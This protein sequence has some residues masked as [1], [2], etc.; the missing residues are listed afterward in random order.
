MS[1]GGILF[2]IRCSLGLTRPHSVSPLLPPWRSVTTRWATRCEEGGMGREETRR[3]GREQR[4]TRP[5]GALSSPTQRGAV[6]AAVPWVGGGVFIV[7]SLFVWFLCFLFSEVSLGV[8]LV[9]FLFLSAAFPHTG[10]CWRRFF[11]SCSALALP[12]IQTAASSTFRHLPQLMR[13]GSC[14]LIGGSLLVSCFLIGR[15]VIHR[16]FLFF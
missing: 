7:I 5:Q 10:S 4:G 2:F 9:C 13:S 16:G 6:P 14:S 15:L 1:L 12:W 11:V 8:R 3:A